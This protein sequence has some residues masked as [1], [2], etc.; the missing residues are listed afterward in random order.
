MER[1]TSLSS[2]HCC[3]PISK[4]STTVAVSEKAA[5]P[6]F[7]MWPWRDM[8]YT[9]YAYIAGRGIEGS[10]SFQA[11]LPVFSLPFKPITYFN[12]FQLLEEDFIVFC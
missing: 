3:F 1:V 4:W 9:K 5:A 10:A 11:G 2:S 8:G 6:K 12:D 7:L